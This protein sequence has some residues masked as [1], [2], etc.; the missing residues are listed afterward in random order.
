M[1]ISIVPVH[2]TLLNMVKSFLLILRDVRQITALLQLAA[3]G[4]E[5]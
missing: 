3:G 1:S 4:W 5:V 2:H